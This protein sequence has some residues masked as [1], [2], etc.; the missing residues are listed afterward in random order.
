MV[1]KTRTKIPHGQ[2][3]FP[4]RPRLSPDAIARMEAEDQD[5]G[6][7]CRAIFDAVYPNLITEHYNWFIVI[8]PDSGDYFIHTD[9]M[10]AF[11]IAKQKYPQALML[12]MRLNE[13]G[14]CGTI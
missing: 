14:T 4:D 1:T 9:E 8:E 10:M 3:L 6:K 2:P 12:A 13:T 11:Q 7:R 5:M